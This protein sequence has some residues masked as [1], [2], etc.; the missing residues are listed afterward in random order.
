MLGT[1]PSLAFTA[2]SSS[3]ARPWAACRLIGVMRSMF[4][5]LRNLPGVLRRRGRRRPSKNNTD[6]S[7]YNTRKGAGLHTLLFAH[8][9]Q[10]GVTGHVGGVR[11]ALDHGGYDGPFDQD[12][13]G[14]GDLRRLANGLFDQP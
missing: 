4:G 10:G 7:V 12:V 9:F 13:Y 11:A 1:R 8:Q 3:L 6:R 2:S 5:L 14:G